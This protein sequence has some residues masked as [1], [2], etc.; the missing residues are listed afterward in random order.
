MVRK[1][2]TGNLVPAAHR[3]TSISPKIIPLCR[4]GLKEWK[5]LFVNRAFGRW[6]ACGLN[7]MVLNVKLAEQIVA[8]SA[9]CFPSLISWLRNHI[10]KSTSLR[11]VTFVI[12]TQNSIVN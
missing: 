11:E 5:L 12:S 6:Q 9:L 3:K 10:L 7:V 1:C 8:A 4:A 2:E